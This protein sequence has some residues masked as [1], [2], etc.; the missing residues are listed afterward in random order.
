MPL[1]RLLLA[2]VFVRGTVSKLNLLKENT[3][4]FAADKPLL[5]PWVVVM[6]SVS[7]DAFFHTM[8]EALTDARTK[9]KHMNALLKDSKER[10]E[11]LD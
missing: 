6:K 10:L 11:R 5:E 8:A 3:R 4:R 1:W 9:E 2:I 7:L